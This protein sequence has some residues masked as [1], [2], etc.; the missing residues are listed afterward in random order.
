[1]LQNKFPLV[2][3]PLLVLPKPSV[4]PLMRAQVLY[5]WAEWYDSLQKV[6]NAE[7][8]PAKPRQQPRQQ[9]RRSKERQRRMP[10]R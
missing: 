4:S 1:M 9:R 6:F 10:A 7:Q 8:Q 2:L 3:G 5:Q